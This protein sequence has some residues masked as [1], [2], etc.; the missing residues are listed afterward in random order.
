MLN[1]KNGAKYLSLMLLGALATGCYAAETKDVKDKGTATNVTF[2]QSFVPTE[3]KTQGKPNVLIISMD[4]LGYGQLNFDEKA[5][6]KK[7]L[8]EKVIPDRYKVDVDKAIEAAKKSTPNLRKL[9]DQGVMLTQDFV[10]HGVS[11]PSRAGFMTS[12]FPSRFGIY[13]N[14]DAQ[15]GV[16]VDHKFLAELFQNHGYDTSAIGKW[17][18]GRITNVPVPKEKQTRDYHDNFTTFCDEP[19]QPQNRGFDYFMGF[20]AAGT[21]YYNSPSLFRNREVVP[22]EGY[23]TDQLTDEALGRIK[24]AGEDPFFIYLA[25]NAPH[26]P[27]EKHAPEKYRVFNTGN[28]EVDKYYESIYAVD[29]NIGRI[30]D[31]LEK[32]GKLENTVIMFFSDNGSVID[33]PL[34]MNGIFTGNKGETFN[35]G[36][37]I[38][39]FITWKAGL[40][41]GKYN[42]M[43]STVDYMPTALAAAGIEI[44]TEW[45]EKIDGVNLLPYLTKEV[46]GNPHSELYWAQPRAFHW[47]PINIPFWRD[48]DKYVTGESD[49]YPVNPYME[50]LSEFSWTVRDNTWTLHYYV[51]DNSYALYDSVKDPQE[52]HNVAEKHPEV[53]KK[54][55]AKMRTY[56]TTKAVKPNTANNLPKYEQ[57]IKATEETPAT[58]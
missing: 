24:A 2:N 26:I 49:Y 23:I 34:P 18:L 38:P 57:L 50:S 32:T 44:P 48:Y 58:K 28:E 22:A 42:K 36:V 47:D 51:G 20:H 37:H 39:G 9:Q 11:G 6:D 14:D 10:C 31:E 7:V 55:K 3:Y 30:I 45:K 40:K 52:I 8:A 16:S 1:F 12:E 43:V 21:A 54:L 4:D 27:L 19:F 5:F 41:A 35:G 13:S 29:S 25:Y 15:D 33:A 56:L 53:V 46:K 17:H